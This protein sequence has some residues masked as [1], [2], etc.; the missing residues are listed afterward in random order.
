MPDIARADA[1]RSRKSPAEWLPR[2]WSGDDDQM[3][4]SD[5][6]SE[7]GSGLNRTALT[8]LKM[9][10]LAAMPRAIVRT[11]IALK[12]GAFRSARMD[13]FMSN[14]KAAWRRRAGPRM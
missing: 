12:L 8:T 9:A 13:C 1:W 10:V 6:S 11:A 14:P 3:R 4:T 7:N 5:D 2:G